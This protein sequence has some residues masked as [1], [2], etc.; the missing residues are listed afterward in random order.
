MPELIQA[1]DVDVSVD[2]HLVGLVDAA[3][4]SGERPPAPHTTGHWLATAPGMVYVE[5]DEDVISA[6]IRVEA[7][8]APPPPPPGEWDR[9]DEVRLELPSG[10]LGTDEV[11]AGGQ[12]EVFALPAA[13]T[14]QARISWREGPF[15][16]D[17]TRG[18]PEANALVQLWQ[19]P[20]AT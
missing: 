6:R 3:S 18:E 2:H 15:D 5:S 4:T 1:Q 8:D 17:G 12:A 13:G 9:S 7:W 14:W 20:P 10:R 16:E 19:D 11:A